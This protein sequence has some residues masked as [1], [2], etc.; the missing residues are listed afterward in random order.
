MRCQCQIHCLIWSPYVLVR[1]SGT[2]WKDSHL[3]MIIWGKHLVTK[4]VFC[5]QSLGRVLR[6]YRH[7]LGH[8]GRQCYF[9]IFNVLP[10]W[11][12]SIAQLKYSTQSQYT[13]TGPNS[14]GTNLIMLTSS[15]AATRVSI[16]KSSVWVGRSS[17]LT[18]LEPTT[19][20][21]PADAFTTRPGSWWMMTLFQFW[22]VVPIGIN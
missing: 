9:N 5:Q 12:I 15:E 19:S 8:F 11:G 1:L 16:S 22:L 13:D 3:P 18:R 10:H 21:F 6:L 4:I 17:Y 14:P 7:K 2:F 20:Q